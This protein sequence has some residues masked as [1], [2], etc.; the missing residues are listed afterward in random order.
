[1]KH[2]FR[3]KEVIF[4]GDAAAMAWNFRIPVLLPTEAN[5]IVVAAVVEKISCL[6]YQSIICIEF[7]RC[8]L[9]FVV[10]E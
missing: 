2:P 6:M 5:K 7:V 8:C 1:M 4:N 9:S 10:G 3:A